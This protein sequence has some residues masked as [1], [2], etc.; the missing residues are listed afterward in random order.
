MEKVQL[1]SNGLEQSKN[2]K[3]STLPHKTST[4]QYGN[5]KRTHARAFS[6]TLEHE[7]FKNEIRQRNKK[8]GLS[9]ERSKA[10]TNEI[11]LP[12]AYHYPIK[13]Q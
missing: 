6:Q 4:I 5:R 1:N 10:R 8:R 13:I 3:S 12:T 9:I 2:D 7:K 11:E